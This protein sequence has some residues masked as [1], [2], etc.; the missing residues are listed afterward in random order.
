LLGMTL[1]LIVAYS[2]LLN[3]AAMR[4]FA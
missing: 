1:L 3:R 2:L 4:R